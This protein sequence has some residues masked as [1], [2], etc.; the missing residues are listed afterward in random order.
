M[1]RVLWLAQMAEW[2]VRTGLEERTRPPVR[3]ELANWVPK[4][5]NPKTRRGRNHK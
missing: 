2:N 4:Q 5:K 3:K 1:G